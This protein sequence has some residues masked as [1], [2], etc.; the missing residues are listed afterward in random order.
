M[1]D[2]D[3]SSGAT[4]ALVLAG[5]DGT[6]LQPLTHRLTGSPIPKQYCRILGERSLLEDTLH[7]IAPVVP[8]ARTMVILNRSHLPLARPQLRGVPR[9]SWIVQPSN[10]DTG[11][12]LLLSLLALREKAGNAV[13]CVFPSD[14]FVADEARFQLYVRRAVDL[15]S[16]PLRPVVL[17][18]IRPD[19]VEPG[20]G[21]IRP[22]SRLEG[23]GEMAAF[24]V[25]GFAEKPA[26]EEA[27]AVVRSGGLWSTFVMAS[28]VDR[29]LELVATSRPD[30]HERMTG[31]WRSPSALE[32]LYAETQP[33]NFSRDVLALASDALVV[34]RAE[35]TGWSDWGTPEAIERTLAAL[36]IEIPWRRAAAQPA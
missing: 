24:R 7:R 29:L 17:L 10:R 32:A 16:S 14:H 25:A 8:P 35:R 21:Y 9:A 34:L 5:G 3:P 36:A 30:D 15:A 6:R 26:Y 19:R 13:V 4:W 11:P 22:A 20:F 1:T 23:E 28:R 18:G 27:R 33:W 2:A 12:G 31:A